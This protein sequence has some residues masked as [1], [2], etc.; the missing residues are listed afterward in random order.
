[1]AENGTT[2]LSF[3]GNCY[4]EHRV[5]VHQNKEGFR[6]LIELLKASDLSF[7]NMECAIQDLSLIHI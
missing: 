5:S 3:T 2:H 6:K 4:I 7:A 1:M